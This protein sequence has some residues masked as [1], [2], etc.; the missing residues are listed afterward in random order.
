MSDEQA[1]SNNSAI[2]G[3]VA[4][5]AIL[6]SALVIDGAVKRETLLSAINGALK[7]LDKR[8]DMDTRQ[9]RSVL[10]T[11]RSAIEMADEGR[12]DG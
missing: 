7:G 2:L 6:T 8:P 4:G 12:G 10:E 3:A 11:M 5:L 9:F 1:P